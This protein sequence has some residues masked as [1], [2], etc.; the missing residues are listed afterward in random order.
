MDYTYDESC[1][2]DYGLIKFRRND[3]MIDLDDDD[4][5]YYQEKR[6]QVY[7]APEFLGT[8]AYIPTASGDVYSFS[9]ILIEIATRNDPYGVCRY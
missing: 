6:S 8:N 2:S 7:K 1:L 5:S 3:D 9:I 4:D